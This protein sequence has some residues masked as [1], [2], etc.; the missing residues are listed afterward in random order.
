VHLLGIS[1]GGF[2]ALDFA[3]RNQRRLYALTLSG[4]LLS[5]EELFRMYQDMSLRFYRAGEV[6]FELYT[7]YFAEPPTAGS[8]L[9]TPTRLCLRFA[10][11]WLG[12]VAHEIILRFR[13]AIRRFS[14]IVQNIRNIQRHPVGA[15][16]SLG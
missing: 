15:F 2:V 13:Y 12:S 3:R 11:Q 4:I 14:R 10:R 7:H 8:Y 5:H 16:R 6:G 9:F 1:Y